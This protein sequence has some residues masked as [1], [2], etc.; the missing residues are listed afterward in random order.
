MQVSVQRCL[1]RHDLDVL[2]RDRVS[3]T[4]THVGRVVVHDEGRRGRSL[5]LLCTSR[6]ERC[7]EGGGRAQDTE[8]G[9]GA[10]RRRVSAVGKGQRAQEKRRREGERGAKG[11]KGERARN[12]TSAQRLVG[13]VRRARNP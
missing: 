11:V 8:E 5:L 10:V 13:R 9:S 6:G 4:S 2:D 3:A 12:E 1:R 7:R